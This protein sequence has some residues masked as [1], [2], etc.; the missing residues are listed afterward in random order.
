MIPLD[1][2]L[3]SLHNL[4]RMETFAMADNEWQSGLRQDLN[5]YEVYKTR[6]VRPDLDYRGGTRDP[7]RHGL[8]KC[9]RGIWFFAHS[10]KGAHSHRDKS[11]PSPSELEANVR[12]SYQ[13]TGRLADTIARFLIAIMTAAFLIAP[14]GFL[15]KETS[16]GAHLV[17]VSIFILAF[18]VFLAICSRATN[19]E[20]MG[21]SA[22]YAAVLVVF[23]SSRSVS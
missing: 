22:A 1:E 15:T 20:I 10:R 18:A 2:A 7:L 12:R 13:N 9:L 6:L 11:D 4:M 16:I 14:L 17:T 23:V 21:A 3:V 5:P 19:Q 8:R